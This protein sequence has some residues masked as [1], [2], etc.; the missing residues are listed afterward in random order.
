MMVSTGFGE[1]EGRRVEAWG[2]LTLSRSTKEK[3]T[4]SRE[5]EMCPGHDATEVR[6]ARPLQIRTGRHLMR[7]REQKAYHSYFNKC[8]KLRMSSSVP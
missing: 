2:A 1:S 6:E 4:R 8:H 5:A 7:D 3:H